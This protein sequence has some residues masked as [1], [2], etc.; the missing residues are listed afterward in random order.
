MMRDFQIRTANEADLPACAQIID[1]Y[2]ESTPWLPRTISSEELS[3]IFGPELLKTRHLLVASGPDDVVAGY[4]SL[5]IETGH[6]PGLY[7]APAHQRCS[8]GKGLLDGAKDEKPDGL[9]LTVF[10]PN[11]DAKRF[12]EREGFVESVEERTEETDEGVPTLM[13]RWAGKGG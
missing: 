4:L 5:N 12:Y 6:I 10:E 11:R 8:I 3:A 1:R 13:M 7:V 9:H 2:I